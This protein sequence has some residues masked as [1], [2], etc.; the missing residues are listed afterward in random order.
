VNLRISERLLGFSI[1]GTGEVVSPPETKSP[2]SWAMLKLKMI[3]AAVLAL[4]LAAPA[5]AQEHS[6]DANN[7]SFVE[8][9]EWRNYGES[10]FGEYD[11]DQS[12]ILDQGE[13]EESDG[14]GLGLAEGDSEGWFGDWDANDDE[15]VAQDEYFSEESFAGYDANDDDR[16]GEDEWFWNE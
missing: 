7:D 14:F 11:R 10:T 1:T 9:D 2:R 12:G 13:Y 6:L 4:G 3:G 5:L 8:Q 15:G 16:L